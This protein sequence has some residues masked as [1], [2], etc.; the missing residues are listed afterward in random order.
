[1]N[2]SIR[3]LIVLPIDLVI[4][5]AALIACQYF[6]FKR[7][8]QTAPVLSVVLAGV[9]A[10]SLTLPYVWFIIPFFIRGRI[11]YL[12]VSEAFAVLVEGFIYCFILKIRLRVGLL[13]SLLANAASFIALYFLD[14]LLLA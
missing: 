6:L 2:A 3:F 7:S 8:V 4:E 11:P 5:C 12:V 9:I 14:F 10:T 13:V 1:M